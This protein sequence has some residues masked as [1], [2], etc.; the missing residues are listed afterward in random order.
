MREH[1]SAFQEHHRTGARQIDPLFKSGCSA[2]DHPASRAFGL[3]V[4]HGPNQTSSRAR[5]TADL[6][7]AGPVR[8]APNR[9]TPEKGG[10]FTQ[11]P[12]AVENPAVEADARHRALELAPAQP[13]RLKTRPEGRSAPDGLSVA[14][15]SPSN[16]PRQAA[17]LAGAA[18]QARAN[19]AIMGSKW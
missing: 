8:I 5:I 19:T 14:A 15:C 11:E 18:A 6:H 16:A 12:A 9:P 7:R 17:W 1:G 13:W 4:D 3:P 2:R 10:L